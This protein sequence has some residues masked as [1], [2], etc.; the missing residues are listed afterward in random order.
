MCYFGLSGSTAK[1]A[2]RTRRASARTRTTPSS[3]RYVCVTLPCF[4]YLFFIVLCYT[5]G[6][7]TEMDFFA[8]SLL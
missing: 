8:M 7:E 4:F 1:Q 5:Y 3:V 2:T 6:T